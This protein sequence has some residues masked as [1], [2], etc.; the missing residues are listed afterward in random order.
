M[1]SNPREW[2][3]T[4]AEPWKIV[5][6]RPTTSFF[7]AMP[8]HGS[9]LQR[10]PTVEDLVAFLDAKPKEYRERVLEEAFG[11]DPYPDSRP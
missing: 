3:K 9:D 4:M 6:L 11:I 2:G 5:A 8:G 10:E 1:E 7:D